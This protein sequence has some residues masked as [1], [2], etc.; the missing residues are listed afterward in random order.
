[1]G[2]TTVAAPSVATASR[3]CCFGKERNAVV[4]SLKFM[5]S[6]IQ[7]VIELTSPPES[8]ALKTS[9]Q[10]LISSLC[11]PPRRL[12]PGPVVGGTRTRLWSDLEGEGAVEV[13]RC[14]MFTY[15]L[16]ILHAASALT[17]VCH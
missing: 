4:S 7:P 9:L 13:Y 15:L 14:F 6:V 5:L 10:S 17:S 12:P 2:L 16:I 1:M 8:V 11:P 3:T